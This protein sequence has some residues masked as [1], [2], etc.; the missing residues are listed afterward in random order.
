M[1]LDACHSADTSQDDALD[2]IVQTNRSAV[3][4]SA[5]KGKQYSRENATWGGGIFTSQLVSH[6]SS[7]P[8]A[9]LSIEELYAKIR[10]GVSAA[11]AGEQTPW[12]RRASWQGAKSINWG[13]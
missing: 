10:N 13:V 3:V 12:L 11:T 7:A 8:S 4:I 1:F 2:K 6:L 9:V 5:S